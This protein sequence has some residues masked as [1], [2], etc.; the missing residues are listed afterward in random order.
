MLLSA[1]LSSVL[2]ASRNGFRG[3][4]EEISLEEKGIEGS[5]TSLV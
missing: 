5:G 3:G 4:V 1:A 2:T